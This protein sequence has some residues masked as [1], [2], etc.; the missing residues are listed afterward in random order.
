MVIIETSI[1]TK[2]ITTLMDDENYRISQNA[3]IAMPDM[4][5]EQKPNLHA[6]RVFK[7]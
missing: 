7:K 6:L 3:L 2:Q 5:K 1:F 4:G